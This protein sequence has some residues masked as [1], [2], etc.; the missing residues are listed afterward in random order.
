V[1]GEVDEAL[2]HHRE[3]AEELAGVAH[4]V[5]PDTREEVLDVAGPPHES[6][7]EGALPEG[8][9]RAARWARPASQVTVR[10]PRSAASR[11]G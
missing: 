5:G 2:A 8:T 1:L 9:S 4:Q 6:R 3:V 11:L 10:P 7:P